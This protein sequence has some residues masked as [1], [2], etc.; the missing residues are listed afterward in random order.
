LYSAK[1]ARTIAVKDK[2]VPKTTTL[3]DIS[4]IVDVTIQKIPAVTIAVIKIIMK[5]VLGFIPTPE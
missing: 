4:G 5:Y 2:I 3:T 1:A